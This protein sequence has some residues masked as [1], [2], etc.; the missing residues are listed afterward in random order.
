[1]TRSPR[2][3]SPPGTQYQLHADEGSPRYSGRAIA[4]LV[5]GI[6]TYAT[7]GLTALA[8]V[9]L[10]HLALRET[11]RLGTRGRW[12]AITGLVL[13]WVSIAIW[14]LA[15]LLVLFEPNVNTPF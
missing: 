4:S 15:L 6:T 14:G 5:C 11:R 3:A 1:M 2:P 8:A 10:G 13:G 7:V 12:M 9:P